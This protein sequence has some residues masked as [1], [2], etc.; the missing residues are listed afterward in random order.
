MHDKIRPRPGTAGTGARTLLNSGVGYEANTDMRT[1][2]RGS[3]AFRK[4]EA[5]YMGKGDPGPAS[6][7]TMAKIDPNQTWKKIDA[8]AKPLGGG[9]KRAE[10]YQTRSKQ[11]LLTQ[12]KK[13]EVPKTKG[14]WQ[15]V[16]R[17]QASASR[18]DIAAGRLGTK[19]KNLIIN[20][21]GRPRGR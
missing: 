17:N 19:L 3:R 6:P 18:R 5:K 9:I 1:E 20:L 4:W 15:T 13:G 11:T 12:Q 21:K 16:L 7:E 8:K 10:G 14:D 2:S